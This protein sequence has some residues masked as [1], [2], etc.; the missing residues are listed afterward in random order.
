MAVKKWGFNSEVLHKM[1][2]EFGGCVAN[3]YEGATYSNAEFRRLIRECEEDIEY[4]LV[5]NLIPV[6]FEPDSPTTTCQPSENASFLM[7]VFLDKSDR[8]HLIGDL[9]EEFFLEMLPRFGSR[10]A[11]L[12]FW[13]QA[14][15]AIAT[16]NTFCKWALRVPLAGGLFRVG[17][18][19]ARKMIGS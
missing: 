14:I 10:Q 17:E 1:A 12:W 16:R 9:E 8:Q 18:W 15:R 13:S 2:E 3:G 6:E 4:F 7:Y 19:I 5:N 11:R